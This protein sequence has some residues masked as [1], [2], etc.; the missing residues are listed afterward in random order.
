MYNVNAK[1]YDSQFVIRDSTTSV[2]STSGGLI[3]EG[4]VSARDTYVRGDVVVNNVKITPNLGDIARERQSILP[5]NI[6]E[7]TTISNFVFNN[8]VTNGI[9]AIIYVSQSTSNTI[10]EINAVY[11]PNTTSWIYNTSFTGDVIDGLDF[12]V[13]KIND[14]AV[15]QFINTSNTEIKIRYRATT[16]APPGIDPTLSTEILLNTTGSF[17]PN[18]LLYATTEKTVGYA[19]GV[20][21]TSGQLVTTGLNST[22]LNVSGSITAGNVITNRINVGNVLNTTDNGNIGIGTSSPNQYTALHIV[23]QSGTPASATSGTIMI[24]HEAP[25][26]VSS[27]VFANSRDGTDYGYIQYQDDSTLNG[28]GSASRL[29][30]GTVN[31]TSDH[32]VFA[33]SGNVGIATES[34]TLARLHVAGTSITNLVF[35]TGSMLVSTGTSNIVTSTTFP[36]SIYSVNWVRSSSGFVVSSDSRIKEDIIDVNDQ[37]A[38]EIL[39]QLQPKTYSYVD[40]ITRG[41][42]RVYGF[43]AQEVEQVLPHA[44]GTSRDYIPNV[45]DISTYSESNSHL[46][47]DSKNFP[48]SVTNGSLLKLYNDKAQEIIVSIDEVVDNNIVRVSS[49]QILSQE[50]YFVYG[51]RVDDFKS[52]NKDAIWTISTAALQEVDR[53]LVDTQNELENTNIQIS[54]LENELLQIKSR[55]SAAG[56]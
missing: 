43:I 53:Q 14:Q 26:G 21:Y 46:T 39:R 38:L 32:I 3:V 28:T 44:V 18:A 2:S 15:V 23:E 17:I 56:L 24:D 34:P 40:K 20:L 5:S 49:S 30:F 4:G 36:T 41:E 31:D 19:N 6:S 55:L 9:K 11:N 1:I 27:I 7:W 47:L 51:Q 37:S 10:W 50:S 45:Y 35:S 52:L 48:Q 29:Y 42:E 8:E 12:R 16:T 33:P 54:N 13:S 25:G 22:N